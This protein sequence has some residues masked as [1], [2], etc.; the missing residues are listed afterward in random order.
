[1]EV[2]ADIWNETLEC[3]A[4]CISQLMLVTC[5]DQKLKL[6]EVFFQLDLDPVV[7]VSGWGGIVGDF[8]WASLPISHWNQ[9]VDHFPCHHYFI[10]GVEMNAITLVNVILYQGGNDHAD[11]ILDLALWVLPTMGDKLS[12]LRLFVS[13]ADLVILWCGLT[14]SLRLENSHLWSWV[15]H[16]SETLVKLFGRSEPQ[17]DMHRA[18]FYPLILPIG[19]PCS[20]V[21]SVVLRDLEVPWVDTHLHVIDD[22]L[23]Y[24]MLPQVEDIHMIGSYSTS[25]HHWS[26][27]EELESIAEQLLTHFLG[28]NVSM[29]VNELLCE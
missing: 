4:Y 22:F 17:L 21:L 7:L 9:V 15:K 29:L 23:A 19:V 18:P 28:Q 5:K 8:P 10:M 14:I 20:A 25:L 6:E 12:K 27:N 2:V 16:L 24:F 26:F 3:L 11:V 13:F 1:M